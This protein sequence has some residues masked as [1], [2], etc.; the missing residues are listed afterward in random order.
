MVVVHSNFCS[1]YHFS[2]HSWN[3]ADI[4]AWKHF[5][6]ARR[7]VHFIFMSSVLQCLLA[8]VLPFPSFNS[9]DVIFTCSPCRISAAELRTV[10]EQLFENLFNA[11][12]MQGSLE[13]EYLMKGRSCFNLSNCL[14][15]FAAFTAIRFTVRLAPF[16][17]GNCW[18][19]KRYLAIIT[20]KACADL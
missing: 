7:E 2:W 19:F 14:D 20:S 8:V 11:L 18:Y 3:T 17:Q 12:D 9:S 15:V 5:S 4:N 16:L 10:K 13:N 1:A 6:S